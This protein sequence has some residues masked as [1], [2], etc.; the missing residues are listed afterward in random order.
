M[1]HFIP[2]W[3]F[4]NN[5]LP[6]HKGK[7]IHR[8]AVISVWQ[9]VGGKVHS[10]CKPN[11]RYVRLHLLLCSGFSQERTVGISCSYWCW[12]HQGSSALRSPTNISG[13]SSDLATAVFLP[14][15]LSFMKG[16][17]GAW[18]VL[19]WLP[20]R[21]RLSCNCDLGIPWE[22]WGLFSVAYKSSGL[23]FTGNYSE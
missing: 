4:R 2:F 18:K 22:I 10:G 9:R 17:W 20:T 5:A 23:V 16:I 19:S 13:I 14:C 3:S 6:E 1:V 11:I 21:G 15:Y 8:R 12:R 7:W